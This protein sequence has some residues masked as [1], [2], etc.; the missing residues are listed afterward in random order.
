MSDICRT[1][2]SRQAFLNIA[3]L[4]VLPVLISNRAMAQNTLPAT[5]NVG[6]GTTGPLS[7]LSVSGQVV[8]GSPYRGDASLHLMQSYGGFGRFIQIQ[9]VGNSQPALNL[10]SDTDLSGN[11][12]WW[13]WG[14]NSIPGQ[15]NP[16]HL[17]AVLR[18]SL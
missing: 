11:N 9:P 2:S 12:E 14:V 13:V 17:L 1:P 5:G 7:P 18:D 8:I 3:I 16:E 15:Y 10:M 4:V 6:I